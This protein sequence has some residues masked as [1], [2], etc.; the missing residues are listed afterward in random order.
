[1]ASAAVVTVPPKL[2]TIREAFTSKATSI[3]TFEILAGISTAF[4]AV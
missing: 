2:T 3:W 1:M 4:D